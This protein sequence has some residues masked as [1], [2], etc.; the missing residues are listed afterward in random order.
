[1]KHDCWGLA[2]VSSTAHDRWLA[3]AMLL[4]VVGAMRGLPIRYR[5]NC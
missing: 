4:S 5:N 1:M 3:N 2:T